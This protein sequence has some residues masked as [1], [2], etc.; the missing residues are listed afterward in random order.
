MSVKQ[1]CI[2]ISNS[3]Y[4]LALSHA[5]SRNLSMAITY[6]KYS[7]QF[8]KQNIPARNLLGLLYYEIGEV[9]E[10]L[11]EWVVSSNISSENNIAIKYIRILRDS[12]GELERHEQNIGKYNVALSNAFADS[13][14]LSILMLNR[15][16]DINPKYINAQL[17]LAL[18][19]MENEDYKKA[20]KCIKAVL[21][22]D[23]SNPIALSYAS[24]LREGGR[25]EAGRNRQF[26]SKRMSKL[27]EDDVIIPKGYSEGF[28]WHTAVNILIGL[29]IGAASII[30][31]YMPTVKNRMNMEHNFEIMKISNQLSA[32]NAKIDELTESKDVLQAEIDRLTEN[33]N[34]S[35]ESSTYQITQY[36]LLIGI[37]DAYRKND[38]T[39]AAFLFAGLDT[40]KLLDI[41][42]GS[43]VSPTSIYNEL[44][45]K[46][47]QDGPK[48]LLDKGNQF[49]NA[50]DYAN[51][52]IYYDKSLLISP[53]FV[54]ALYKKG[55]AYKLSGD[56][57]NANTIFGDIII[58]YPDS[59]EA[60]QAKTERGY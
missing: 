38:F 50:G 43:R 6:I 27:L 16:T 40:D 54:P 26:E 23:K 48:L 39:Q 11:V 9:A 13:K 10:A 60:K 32:S 7:L 2:Y 57:Q 22:V 37:L 35:D 4:N 21:N 25:S 18:L 47:T 42:D 29:L 52:I 17:L 20:G 14:D 45:A 41:D 24:K 34:T 49:F 56:S 12:K 58:N 8:N 28:G 19:A 30:F 1:R 55:M 36:Q 59:N 3:Y 15:I 44:S 33:A 46:I 31:L 53:S 5:K 51:A